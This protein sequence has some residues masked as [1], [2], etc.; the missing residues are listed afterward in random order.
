MI[1]EIEEF[2]FSRNLPI[3]R[4]IDIG[5]SFHGLQRDY[6]ERAIVKVFKEESEL[7]RH[8]IAWRIFALARDTRSK[9][10]METH[11]ARLSTIT[12][13]EEPRPF[14]EKELKEL[15]TAHFDLPDPAIVIGRTKRT[16]SERLFLFPAAAVVVFIAVVAYAYLGGLQ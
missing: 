5:I 9:D 1:A 4:L 15:A 14:M 13:P 12:K 16:L 11:I 10:L 3:D 7:K 2:Y 6:I 8:Q